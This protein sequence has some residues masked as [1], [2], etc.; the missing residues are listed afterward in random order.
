MMNNKVKTGNIIF[1]WTCHLLRIND[2]LIDNL[3][4]SYNIVKILIIGILFEI[5]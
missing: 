5:H 2:L 3:L 4:Q 1:T